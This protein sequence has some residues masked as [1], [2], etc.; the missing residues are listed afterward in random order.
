[1]NKVLFFGVIVLCSSF[2][3]A[4]WR[5]DEERPASA[6]V[7]DLIDAS[8]AQKSGGVSAAEGFM[9]GYGQGM[10]NNQDLNFMLEMQRRQNALEQERLDMMELRREQEESNPPS[11]MPTNF[12]TRTDLYKSCKVAVEQM[13]GDV[14]SEEDIIALGNFYDVFGSILETQLFFVK[15]KFSACPPPGG[16]T[17]KQAIKATYRYLGNHQEKTE[18]EFVTSV[19]HA[20]S[21]EFP[22]KEVKR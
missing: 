19:V 5:Y 18:E 7:Q 10:Q 11:R 22:C 2:A 20:L 6:S 3:Y 13:D 16:L 15:G 4:D 17:N 1:M 9:R 14:L 21:H 12:K 8:K